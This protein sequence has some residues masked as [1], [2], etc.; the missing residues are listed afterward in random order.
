MPSFVESFSESDSDS[1]EAD[2]S[3]IDAQESWR[4]QPAGVSEGRLPL[5]QFQIFLSGV[6]GRTITVAVVDAHLRATMRR[7]AQAW[8]RLRELVRKAAGQRFA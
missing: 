7:R 8:V 3:Q 6:H 2:Y 1:D 5:R 4:P